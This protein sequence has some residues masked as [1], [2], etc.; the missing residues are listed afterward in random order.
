MA[1]D[2]QTGLGDEFRLADATDALVLI[3]E[4]TNIPIPS[5]SSELIDASHYATT[6]FRD[7]IQSP[8]QDGEE[9][10]I[11]INWIPNSATDILL[12]AAVGETR[13]FEIRVFQDAGVLIFTGSVLVRSYNRTNPMDD[14]RSG[15]L[16]VKWVSAITE[17][18]DA[19][20]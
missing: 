11:E 14:K 13:D 12:K 15:T 5:G 9:A 20:P 2:V 3:G 10:D 17:T 16:T 19:T 18:W 7:Y 1:T 4:I 6:G 8:L